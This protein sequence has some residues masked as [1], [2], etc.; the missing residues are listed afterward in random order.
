MVKKNIAAVT[1]ITVFLMAASTTAEEGPYGKCIQYTDAVDMADG[2]VAC[3][4][5]VKELGEQP[6]LVDEYLSI[7]SSDWEALASSELKAAAAVCFSP[8]EAK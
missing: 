5:F 2:N 4:C 3:E 8:R 7:D 1:G 6:A